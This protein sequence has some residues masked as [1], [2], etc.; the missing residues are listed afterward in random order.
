M[1]DGRGVMGEIQIKPMCLCY[2]TK[3]M[4]VN[5]SIPCDSVLQ[6]ERVKLYNLCVSVLQNG[7]VTSSPFHVL[8]KVSKKE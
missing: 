5:E 3:W 4:G 2:T 6:N 7:W 1:L 8:G